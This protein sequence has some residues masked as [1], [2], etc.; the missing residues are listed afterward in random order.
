MN[1]EIESILI[2]RFGRDSLIA[3]ATEENGVPSVRAVNA[4]YIDGA[5]YT[6]TYLLSN[7]I[8]QIEKNSAVGVCGEWFTGHGRGESLGWIGRKENEALAARLRAAFA[9]WYQN[10][11][12]NEEDANTIILKVTLTDGVVMKNGTRYTF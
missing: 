6:V 9:S 2:E 8:R 4:V 12:V 7:K 3:L 5:F 11:H 10:G 1:T